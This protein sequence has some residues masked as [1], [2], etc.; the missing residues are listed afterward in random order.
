MPTIRE[1]NIQHAQLGGALHGG[2]GAHRLLGAAH[3]AAPTRGFLLHQAKATRDIDRGDIERCHVGRVQFHTHLTVGPADAFDRAQPRH[4]EQPLGDGVVDKPTEFLV[5][6]F[7]ACG[8]RGGKGQHGAPRSGYLGD[9]GV[10]QFAGQIGTD[11]RNRVAH[12]VYGFGNGLFQ[13]KLDRHIHHT[14]QYFG[15]DIFDALQR[16]DRVFDLA[17]NIGF[18]LRRRSPRERSANGHDW[19]LDIRKILY[20]VTAIGE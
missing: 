14:I 6:E 15:E 16:R 2:D 8:G 4:T 10:A 3:I 7:A 9:G 1:R 5:V 18:Q 19:Q 13:H 12:I 17:R 11:S 20:F